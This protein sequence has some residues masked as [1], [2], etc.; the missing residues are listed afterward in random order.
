[1]QAER[2]AFLRAGL[3]RRGPRRARGTEAV[4]YSGRWA[5][6]AGG[7]RTAQH[8]RGR[9]S[10]RVDGLTYAGLPEDASVEEWLELLRRTARYTPQPYQQLAA[11]YRA[12]GQDREARIVLIEQRR[13]ELSRG[14]LSAF[15]RAWIRSPGL[16]SATATSLGAHCGGSRLLPPWRSP[17]RSC[18]GRLVALRARAQDPCLAQRCSRSVSVS[19]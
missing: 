16:R 13:D 2:G 17:S 3:Y 14:H 4:G 12:A 10:S 15:V 7:R 8:D 11:G 18:W 1:M 5:I 19:T 9:P 6:E